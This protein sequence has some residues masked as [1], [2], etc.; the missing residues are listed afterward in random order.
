MKNALLVEQEDIKQMLAEKYK[1][2]VS[3]IVRS[4]YSYAVI[5]DDEG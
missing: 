2:P 3:N 4:Q 1:V 5:L